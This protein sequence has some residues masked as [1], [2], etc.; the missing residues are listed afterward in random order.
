MA[1][2]RLRTTVLLL[3]GLALVGF[4]VVEARA[5]SASEVTR[6]SDAGVATPTRISERRAAPSSLR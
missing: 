2:L 3:V 4:G 6:A 5:R 1:V